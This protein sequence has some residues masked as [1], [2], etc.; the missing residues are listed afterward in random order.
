MLRDYAER[1]MRWLNR[2]RRPPNDPDSFVRHPVR[3]GPPS[4][5]AAVALEEPAPRR[6]ID[7]FG[8]LLRK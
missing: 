6:L 5:N 4:L 2:R 8:A 7:L 3:R 1:V